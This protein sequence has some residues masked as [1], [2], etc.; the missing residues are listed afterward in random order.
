[1]ADCDKNVVP[2]TKIILHYFFIREKPLI[3]K[4]LINQARFYVR[5]G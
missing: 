5:C 2:N 1:M 3:S 4:V